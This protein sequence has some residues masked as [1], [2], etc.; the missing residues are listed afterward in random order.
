MQRHDFTNHPCLEIGKGP[1]QLSLPRP[2]GASVQGPA[3]RGGWARRGAGGCASPPEQQLAPQA[4][5]AA[6][7]RLPTS[8]SSA[9]PPL[10][11][12]SPLQST[13]TF[14]PGK[15]LNR[16]ANQRS[17][18]GRGLKALLLSAAAAPPLAPQRACLIL[19]TR[20]FPRSPST[21]GLVSLGEQPITAARAESLDG[22]VPRLPTR[23][24]ICQGE[25]LPLKPRVS[26]TGGISRVLF[27]S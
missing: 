13:V 8:P 5:G 18:C 21:D 22:S 15:Q 7:L 19:V 9:I 3:A 12:T 16:P 26:V 17:S 24:S 25:T 14:V 27:S 6:A 23:K 2:V 1:S 4:A 20:N 10:P 11:L